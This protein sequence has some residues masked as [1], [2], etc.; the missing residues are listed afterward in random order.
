MDQELGDINQLINA[1]AIKW[2]PAEV[3]VSIRPGWFYHSKEDNSVKSP[4]KLLDIYFSSVGKNSSLLLNIPPNR[5]GLI[6]DRDANVLKVFHY[7]L[8]Q[9][10]IK[11]WLR[12]LPSTMLNLILLMLLPMYWITNHLPTGPRE[13]T[14]RLRT[15]HSNGK[16]DLV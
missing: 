15:W 14:I 5:D 4:E 3:D 8:Q 13:K 6:S 11:I 7:S 9:I 12:G 10:L 16:T 1:N 2:Y